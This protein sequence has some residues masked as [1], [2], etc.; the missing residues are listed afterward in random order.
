MNS[1]IQN[2]NSA[3]IQEL[4]VEIL[5]N[6]KNTFIQ[7]LKQS[8]IFILGETHGVKENADI[9][10]TLFK[11]FDFKNLALEWGSEVKEVVDTYIK[12]QSFSFEL[13]K[14]HA[15]GRVTAEHFA[16]IKKLKE[17]GLLE[18]IIYFDSQSQSNDWNTRDKNMAQ[19]ILNFKYSNPTLIMTGNLHA[20][21]EAFIH[22]SATEKL[23]PMGEH[24]KNRLSDILFG[25]IKYTGGQ[26][27]NFGVHD[28]GKINTVG[29]DHTKF[30]KNEDNLYIFEIPEA[31]PA[32]A[33]N[34]S[35]SL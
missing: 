31:H 18:E 23:H 17:E 33:P 25:K 3:K 28:F 16:V 10:Y 7:E 6:S 13:I 1:F 30:Y 32:I 24:L 29:N 20:R 21:T 11:L 12:T 26:Y 9:I 34:Q 14:D 22:K 8:N 19:N 4:P 2:I 5:E 35:I 15:D 27:Y